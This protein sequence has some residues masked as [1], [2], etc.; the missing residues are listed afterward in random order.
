MG[1]LL[2]NLCLSPYINFRKMW[3]G[4]TLYRH[5]NMDKLSSKLAMVFPT[6][7]QLTHDS[8]QVQFVFAKQGFPYWILIIHD[9]PMAHIHRG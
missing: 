5:Q 4:N 6:L 7:K 9:N 8:A 3:D 2:G 1:M